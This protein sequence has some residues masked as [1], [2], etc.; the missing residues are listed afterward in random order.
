MLEHATPLTIRA[1]ER[2]IVRVFAM[3]MSA[4]QALF[5]ND[6]IAL[7]Q[8][9]GVSDLDP[10]YVEIFP[11]AD[12]DQLGLAGY[13]RDGCGV[14]ENIIAADRDRLN[15]LAGYVMLVFS[16][17]FGGRAVTMALAQ[18]ISLI[19]T[20][21]E[22]KT[23]WSGDRLKSQSAELYPGTRKSP[24]QGRISTR[25]IGAIVATVFLLIVTAIVLMVI[26]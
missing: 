23:D 25:R 7:E 22:P 14:A 21:N 4:E 26:L 3:N 24:E 10:S 16:R 11:L 1:S 19:A 2:G 18:T 5:Q 17:A 15:A 8:M 12:L 9:L 20:Y 13:L 6:P